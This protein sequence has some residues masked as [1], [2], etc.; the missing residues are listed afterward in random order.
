[1]EVPFRRTSKTITDQA[2]APSVTMIPILIPMERRIM[3]WRKPGDITL[4][5]ADILQPR[6]I[7][8]VHAAALEVEPES[9][10]VRTG[11]GELSY[12]YLVVSTGPQLAFDEIP[13]LG[14][15]KGHTDCTFTIDHAVRT[16]RNWQ[17]I[18]DN[19][20][21][22]VVGSAQMVSCFGP[23]YELAFEMDAELSARAATAKKQ[24]GLRHSP[25]S[26]Q[27]GGPAVSSAPGPRSARRRNRPA[28]RFSP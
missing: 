12:D 27:P 8:F 2:G 9:R 5:V 18:L 21:P 14:P 19:P 25:P 3:G 20:G 23:S 6:G 4:K 28:Q 24:N 1:M 7:N 22:V 17:A 16:G 26:P 11:L 13:G 15:D 10:R